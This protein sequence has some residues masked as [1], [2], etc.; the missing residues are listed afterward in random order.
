MMVDVLCYWQAESVINRSES[1][2]SSPLLTDPDTSTQ[3]IPLS[4]ISAV[5]EAASET[6][7]VSSAAEEQTVA[8]QIESADKSRSPSPMDDID[9]T[10]PYDMTQGENLAK[11]SVSDSPDTDIEGTIPY[12]MTQG[13]FDNGGNKSPGGNHIDIEPTIPYAMSDASSPLVDADESPV[14]TEKDAT[15]GVADPTGDDTVTLNNDDATAGVTDPTVGVADPTIALGDAT[16]NNDDATMA[17]GATVG[18]ADPTVAM[19]A[20]LDA[21]QAMDDDP[22]VGI[23]DEPLVGLPNPTTVAVDNHDDTQSIGEQ[24][25]QDDDDDDATLDVVPAVDTDPD[26]LQLTNHNASTNHSP[27]H[28]PIETSPVHSP[29]VAS[30]TDKT[31]PII[32]DSTSPKSPTPKKVQFASTGCPSNLDVPVNDLLNDEESPDVEVSNI[33][34]CFIPGG[35]LLTICVLG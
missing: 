19:N 6:A 12:E 30:H 16:M 32:K 7:A 14:V 18:V 27:T 25:Q 17:I 20:D 23:V 4:E 13:V 22:T 15:V 1:L 35:D 10:I 34:N 3:L 28:T 31:T 5:T 9:A 26:H 24:Q 29:T 8:Y 21:T 2:S 11:S 33:M